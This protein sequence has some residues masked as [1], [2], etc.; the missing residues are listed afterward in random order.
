MNRIWASESAPSMGEF[1]FF[2]FQ[3]WIKVGGDW[4]ELKTGNG[5][6]KSISHKLLTWNC[7]SPSIEEEEEVDRQV[8]NRFQDPFKYWN[9]CCKCQK[10]RKD[11]EGPEIEFLQ[12]SKNSFQNSSKNLEISPTI[13]LKE[14]WKLKNSRKIFENPENLRQFLLKFV[15]IPKISSKIHKNPQEIQKNP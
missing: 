3:L 2:L 15:T 4:F 10:D 6:K 14:S 1:F 7:I 13:P 11:R 8:E 12:I 9:R 5:Q